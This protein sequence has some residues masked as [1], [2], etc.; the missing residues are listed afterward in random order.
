MKI[1]IGF[2]IG[3]AFAFCAL[4]AGTAPRAATH[5]APR[6][7]KLIHKA[8]AHH[9]AARRVA[10]KGGPP[11]CAAI[12]YRALPS[13]ASDGEQQAGFYKS[14][15][16]ALALRATVKGGQA[17]EYYVVANGKRLAAASGALPQALAQCAAAKKLP[18]PGTALS[19][20]TGEGFRVLIAH[21]GKER[22]AALYAM[23]GGTWHFCNA[24]SF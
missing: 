12:S 21:A 7:E 3:L 4:A 18:A 1:T 16:V 20:C 2:G 11:A 23:A 13:G 15:F 24:G 22:L 14:R 9:G 10:A 19:P 6:H 17:S 5:K 8:A